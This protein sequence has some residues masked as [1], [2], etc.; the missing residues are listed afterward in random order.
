MKSS[1]LI[2]LGAILLLFAGPCRATATCETHTSET[3]CAKDKACIWHSDD[4]LCHFPAKPQEFPVS[5]FKTAKEFNDLYDI[6]WHKALVDGHAAS[7]S[8]TDQINN[9][10]NAAW[11]VLCGEWP[12][13][14]DFRPLVVP[15]CTSA[16][17]SRCLFFLPAPEKMVRDTCGRAASSG[18]D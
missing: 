18:V 14:C 16:W 9:D 3:E 2:A 17:A 10:I 12:N 4:A 1:A 7:E 8:K 13:A 11:L 6:A 15:A 5:A